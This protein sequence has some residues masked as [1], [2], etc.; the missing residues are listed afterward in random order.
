MA[1]RLTTEQIQ[2][3]VVSRQMT[4][5]AVVRPLGWTVTGV[6]LYEVL[7]PLFLIIT[8]VRYPVPTGLGQLLHLGHGLDLLPASEDD[9]SIGA[10]VRADALGQIFGGG[11]GFI[12]DMLSLG[13]KAA[14]AGAW[15][16]DG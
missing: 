7:A 10:G 8:A 1:Q 11:G 12:H 16:V 2:H 14:G 9:R 13:S 6:D 15:W 4:C 5:P 3:V